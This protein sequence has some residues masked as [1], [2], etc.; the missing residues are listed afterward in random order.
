MNAQTK[1]DEL[2][3]LQDDFINSLDELLECQA[4]IDGDRM[5]AARQIKKLIRDFWVQKFHISAPIVVS[6]KKEMREMD[7]EYLKGVE[8]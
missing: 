3:I 5:I 6:S 4:E 7:E 1:L 2:E 8:K